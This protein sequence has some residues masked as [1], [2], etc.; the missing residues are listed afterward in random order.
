MNKALKTV[1]AIP[2][3]IGAGLI[4]YM[5]VWAVQYRRAAEPLQVL[6][7]RAQATDKPYYV[8]LCAAL[9]DNPIG[10]PGHCYVAWSE[11]EPKDIL[12]LDSAGFVPMHLHDQ[13]PSLWS[14]VQ[15]TMVDH[16]AIGNTRNLNA[17][18]VIVDA[19]RYRSSRKL[20]ERWRHRQFQTGVSDCV[21]YVDD[22]A[23][24]LAVKTPPRSHK[25]PQDYLRDLKA[26]NQT[27]S[28]ESIAYHGFLDRNR[29]M[30]HGAAT[31]ST[32][33]R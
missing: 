20:S 12:A 15:G 33:P 22:I 31:A 8:I 2:L 32:Y 24:E 28:W 29:L 1:V 30:R 10:F 23:K 17:L 21:A 13:V 16:A 3:L 6:D 27:Q 18:V 25:F 9:A 7:L 4:L 19:D 11:R 5:A 14:N 26:I